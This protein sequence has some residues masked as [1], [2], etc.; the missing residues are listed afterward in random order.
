L[1]RLISQP[2][3]QATPQA[4]VGLGMHYDEA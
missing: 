2:L 3:M 4:L 1:H